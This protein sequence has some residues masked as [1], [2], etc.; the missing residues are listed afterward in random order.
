M[1][2]FV[3]IFQIIKIDTINKTKLIWYEQNC[4]ASEPVFVEHPNAIVSTSIIQNLKKCI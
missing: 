3:I 1:I 2:H 4:Y